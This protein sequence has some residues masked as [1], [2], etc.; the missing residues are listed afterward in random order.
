MYFILSYRI[1][2]CVDYLC[3]QSK[4]LISINYDKISEQAS[5][6]ILLDIGI[7]GVL[8]NL[9]PCHIFTEKPNSTVILNCPS[10]LVNYYLA[11][12]II[13]KKNSKKLSSV[14]NDLKLRIHVID[15]QKTDFVTAKTTEISSVENIIKKLHIQ[16]D[17][18]LFYKKN[19]IMIKKR[20]WINFL[21]NTIFPY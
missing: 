15:K 18:H 13:I 14:P 4:T 10:C 1:I 19:Y 2:F 6:N 3:C 9:V 16:S 17:F 11:K 7:P 5:Y 8:I 12:R 20:K 21:M